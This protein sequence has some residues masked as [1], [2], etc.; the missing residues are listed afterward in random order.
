MTHHIYFIVIYSTML[1]TLAQELN[2]VLEDS[3][4]AKLLSPFGRRIYFP[5]GIIAQGGEA[6]KYGKVANGTVGMTVSGGVPIVLPCIQREAP[7]LSPAELVAYAPTAGSLELRTAWKEKI[8]QKNPSLAGVPFSLPVVVPGLTAGIAYLCEL[9]LEPGDTL[10]AGNPS[11]DNYP[12]IVETRGQA[13][14]RQFNMFTP[15]G[16]DGSFNIEAFKTVLHEE[17]EKKTV[18]LLLNFPHNPS[19]YSPTTNE[20]QAICNE[21]LNIAE[22]GCTVMVWCDDAYFGL[23]YED[24]I[25]RESLFAR[26]AGLHKNI[27]AVKIDGPTKED[28]VWGFRTG[29]VTFG[30]KGCSEAHYEALIKKFMGA[31]RSSVSCCSTPAQNIL[32]HAFKA[33]ELEQEK[34]EMREMLERRYR[35]VRNFVAKKK[36]HPVLEPLPFN[37]GYFMAF[38]CTGI[39]AEELRVKLLHEKGIGTIAIDSSTLRI[40]FSSIDENLI[41][42]VYEAIYITAEELARSQEKT[43]L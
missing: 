4:A 37:S 39:D 30:G 2:A 3:P 35:R 13:A 10:I 19:G 42:E 16:I 12:L 34:N 41:D 8:V 29:F 21:I 24:N 23:D 6:K 17:A 7:G 43:D 5:K 20:A 1:H 25:E 14:F 27:L 38:H 22:A 32:L 18:R 28:Y 11:W 36:H 26:R 31:I 33:P 15:G 9:F 40:A